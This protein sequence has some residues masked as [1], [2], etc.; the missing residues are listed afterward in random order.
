ML[1]FLDTYNIY[2]GKNNILRKNKQQEK[3]NVSSDACTRAFVQ[4]QRSA[5]VH[6]CK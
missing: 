5:P 6:S 3:M 2:I 1:F 4:P